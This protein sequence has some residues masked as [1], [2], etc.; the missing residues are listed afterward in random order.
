ME[1]EDDGSCPNQMVE[2]IYR[3]AAADGRG[4]QASLAALAPTMR[5]CPHRRAKI[6]KA[7]SSVAAISMQAE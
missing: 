5:L 3:L 1:M 4:E 7:T 2:D 6:T